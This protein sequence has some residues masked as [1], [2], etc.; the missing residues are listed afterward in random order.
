MLESVEL[1]QAI[2]I[3]KVRAIAIGGDGFGIRMSSDCCRG[4]FGGGEIIASLT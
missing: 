2:G 4:D 3:D 1:N